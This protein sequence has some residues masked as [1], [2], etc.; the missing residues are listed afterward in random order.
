MVT[1]VRLVRRNDDAPPL[2]DPVLVCEGPCKTWTRHAIRYYAHPGVR[3]AHETRYACTWC[4]TI[5]VWG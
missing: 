5:R 2:V 4:N 3:G 1:N